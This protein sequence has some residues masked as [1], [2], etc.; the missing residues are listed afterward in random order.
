MDSKSP[1]SVAFEST[2]GAGGRRNEEG[3]MQAQDQAHDQNIAAQVAPQG[4]AEAASAAEER[5]PVIAAARRLFSNVTTFVQS[6]LQATG[7]EYELLEQMNQRAASE[8]KDFADF[9][10]G[11]S[12]FVER[13]Q[14]KSA[15]LQ[16]YV[17]YIARIDNEVTELEAVVSVLDSYTSTLESRLKAAL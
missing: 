12:V 9:A 14:S 15:A 11:M 1:A 6:E 5:D 8:Y 17:Q 13:L 2:G 3:E 4:G 10:A 7:A 16:Q